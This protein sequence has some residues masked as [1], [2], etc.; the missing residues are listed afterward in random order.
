MV[1]ILMEKGYSF[2]T[3]AEKEIVKNI[4]ETLSFIALDYDKTLE[5]VKNS[6]E[7]QKDYELPDGQV[8]Q[9]DSERF[10]CPEVLFQPNFIGREYPGAQLNF[11]LLP[12]LFDSLMQQMN[13]FL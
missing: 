9:I 4:K 11:L 3:T 2:T 8:I 7:H 1:K 12:M 5:E 6:T 13:V 10:R